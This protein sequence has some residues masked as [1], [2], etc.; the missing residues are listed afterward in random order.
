MKIMKFRLL[1]LPTPFHW[2]PIKLLF[3]AFHMFLLLLTPLPWTLLHL[4]FFPYKY[5][6]GNR[7]TTWLT[8]VSLLTVMIGVNA[9]VSASSLALSYFLWF[10]LSKHHLY[11]FPFPSDLTLF[12]FLFEIMD[13]IFSSNNNILK[14]LTIH[15]YFYLIILC[16]STGLWMER[17]D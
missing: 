5:K 1:P 15:Y 9:A 13:I 4:L 10:L 16:Y 7:Q 11:Q 17:F 2:L 14:T 8:N 6:Q 3:K 12:V